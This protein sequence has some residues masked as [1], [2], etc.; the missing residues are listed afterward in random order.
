MSQALDPLPLVTNC[1]TFSD[2]F[3]SSVMNFMDGAK[4][5]LRFE[6]ES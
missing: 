5:N 6:P 2:P 3:P 4:M 1:H